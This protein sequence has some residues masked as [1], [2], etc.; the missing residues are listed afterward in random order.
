[1]ETIAIIGAGMAGLTAA[2]VLAR[3]GR[4]VT[5]FEK[6]RGTGGRLAT[7]REDAGAFDHGAPM[8]QGDAAFDAAMESIGAE[9]YGRGWRGNPGMS[10]LVKPLVAG[11]QI[12]GGCRIEAVSGAKGDW[13]LTDADG[14]LHGPYKELIVAIPAPQA[15][16]LLRDADF[17][18]V[19]M[20]AQ[21]TLMATWPGIEVSVQSK[22]FTAICHQDR[23]TSKPGALVAHAD[24]DWS[25]THLEDDPETVKAALISALQTASG[26]ATQPS[27]ATVHRWRYART[28]RPLGAPFLRSGSGA[29][30]GGDWAFGPNAGDA[31]RSGSAMA[32]AVLA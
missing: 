11:L 7:R 26:V 21:W 23:I 30:L 25:A 4:T 27:F 1:M 22:P 6:S 13:R 31:W 5:V 16:A 3:A 15:A 12:K 18:N 32:Q 19:E 8:A 28:A 17:S 9:R 29:F 14:I 24:L 10:G 2:H 20:A